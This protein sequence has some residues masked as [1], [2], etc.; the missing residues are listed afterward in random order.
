M[1]F[2]TQ[3]QPFMTAS[4]GGTPAASPWETLAR[5][6]ATAQA[7]AEVLNRRYLL[8]PKRTAG[9]GYDDRLTARLGC[10][11][12]KAYE[13]LQVC[14]SQGGLRHL[15]V[16]NKYIVSEQAVRDL[17]GDTPTVAATETTPLLLKLAA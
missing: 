9:L 17:F 2:P 15:R 10:G 6:Q 4:A 7:E 12:T 5:L 11:K 3:P 13:L 14:P 1:S 8:S 16:G